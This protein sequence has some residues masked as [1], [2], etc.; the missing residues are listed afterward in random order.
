MASIFLQLLV[1]PLLRW[2]PVIFVGCHWLP[3][4]YIGIGRTQWNPAQSIRSHLSRGTTYTYQNLGSDSFTFPS[5][6]KSYFVAAYLPILC[7]LSLL[8]LSHLTVYNGC[9]AS[10]RRRLP[11]NLWAVHWGGHGFHLELIRPHGSRHQ[12]AQAPC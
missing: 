4:R 5:I 8:K 3:S 6:F 12:I 9:R 7:R 1:L 11:A 2:H 10:S